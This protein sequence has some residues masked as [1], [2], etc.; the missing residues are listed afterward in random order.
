MEDIIKRNHVTVIGT[1]EETII[2]GHGFGCD[3]NVW[4]DIIPFFEKDYRIVLF[5]YVGSGQSDKSKYSLGKYADLRGYGKD[6]EEILDFMKIR[7]AIFVGHS[8]SS[9]IG[10]LASIHNPDYFKKMVLLSPSPRYMNDGADYYGG[11]D[12]KDINEIL[13]F[14]EMNFLGWASANAAALIDNPDKPVLTR[15]LKE[16]LTNETPEIMKNFARATFLSDYRN[17]VKQV[18]IPTLILQCSVDSIVPIQVAEYLNKNI[19]NSTLKIFESRG[20]Y[21]HLS[22]PKETAESILEYIK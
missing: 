10:V 22:M 6:L 19:K 12:L 13:T 2:F 17:E 1:G 8:V 9:M 14:M 4:S 7:Q 16:T 15:K 11:F 5:D 3:Q 21:P 18:T 20:H